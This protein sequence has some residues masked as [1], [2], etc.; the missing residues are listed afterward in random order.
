MMKLLGTNVAA[1]VVVAAMWGAIAW[2]TSPAWAQTADPRGSPI[3]IFPPS[4]DYEWVLDVDVT[5]LQPVISASLVGPTDAA[6][7]VILDHSA[8]EEWSIV[9]LHITNTEKCDSNGCVEA[10]M[11]HHP[12][13]VSALTE[14]PTGPNQ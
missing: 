11:R 5:N 14:A 1:T 9:V 10:I 2:A 4:P 13:P 3:Q 8:Q 7:C 12:A 6:R